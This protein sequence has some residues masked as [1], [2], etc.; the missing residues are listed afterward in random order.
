MT[1]T[2]AYCAC[3]KKIDYNT[4]KRDEMEN[5]DDVD[6]QARSEATN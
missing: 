6:F 5:A 3:S 1:Y 4:I 2:A